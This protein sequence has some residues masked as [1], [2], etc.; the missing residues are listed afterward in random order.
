MKFEMNGLEWVIKEVS[1]KDFLE[2]NVQNDIDEKD[3]FYSGRTLII[4]QEIWIFKD[5]SKGLKRRV[6]YHELMH[7]YI[8]SYLTHIDMDDVYEEAWCD[9]SSNSHDIIHE[10]AENYFNK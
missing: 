5:L 10:I 3:K 8:I 9:I 6:L 1:Q 7:C 2:Y 4:E